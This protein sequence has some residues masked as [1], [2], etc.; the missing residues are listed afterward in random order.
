[1]KS[2]RILIVE[3]EAKLLPRLKSLYQSAFAAQDF[4]AV[5]IELAQTVEEA[6]NL[7]RAA[8]TNPYDLVSLDVNLGDRAETGLDVLGS[9][10]RFQSAWMVAL[11]TGVETDASANLTLGKTRAERLRQRLRNDAYTRFPAERLLVVEKPAAA[12][13]T[14]EAAR[15]LGNRVSQIVLIYKEMSRLRYIFRPI[16]VV[17]LERIKAPR[18]HRAK[19]KFIEIE[20]LHWQVRFNCGDLRTLPDRTGFRTLHQLL[21]MAGDESLPAEQ[22]LAIEPKNEKEDKKAATEGDPVAAYFNAQ[23]IA[24]QALSLPEQEKLIMA[25]LSLRFK[26]YVELRGYQD[27]GELS[28]Q[29]EEQLARMKDEMGPLLETAETAYQRLTPAGH[30]DSQQGLIPDEAAQNELHAASGNFE[31]PAAWVTIR[32][33]PGISGSVWSGRVIICE[34]TDLR[35]SPRISSLTSCPPAPTGAT[36]PRTG[37][38]GLRRQIGVLAHPL[39]DAAQHRIACVPVSRVFL[40]LIPFR[41]PVG[42]YRGIEDASPPGIVLVAG[43]GF[44]Q[45]AFVERIEKSIPQRKPIPIMVTPNDWNGVSGDIRKRG[46][47]P[48]PIFPCKRFELTGHLVSPAVG[49]PYLGLQNHFE[50]V[51]RS[52]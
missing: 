3:D 27:D 44:F 43:R 29:E 52:V 17:S 26:R 37:S 46:D 13:E 22:A 36:I 4:D 28:A 1:M 24:W 11:L 6:R 41:D 25:A 19:R 38:N 2:V 42:N 14:A 45:F 49:N 10:K 50:V 7:A 47:Q 5:T 20:S 34:R 8:I 23:G 40:R 33:A 15:L 31:N 9:L 51:L 16:E 48:K 39:F 12:L 32:R 18:G 35:I 30:E 21:A